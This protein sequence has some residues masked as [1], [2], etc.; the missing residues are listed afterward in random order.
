[1]HP[2]TN[3]VILITLLTIGRHLKHITT[4]A[5]AWIGSTKLVTIARLVTFALYKRFWLEMDF[6]ELFDK[7]G[8]RTL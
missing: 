5:Q 1:M 4:A 8:N 7:L 3:L 6:N 2:S